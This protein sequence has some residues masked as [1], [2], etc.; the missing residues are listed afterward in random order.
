[1]AKNTMVKKQEA[2][3]FDFSEMMES[4][5]EGEAINGMMGNV[6]EA[7][8]HQMR[9]AFDLTKLVVE[10]NPG[11]MNEEAI[12]LAFKRAS[13]V[14]AENLPLKALWEKLN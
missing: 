2:E 1:M 12:F 7:S 3:V 13:T 5:Y 14:V 6:I 10:K 4:P 9:L 11:N 8:N